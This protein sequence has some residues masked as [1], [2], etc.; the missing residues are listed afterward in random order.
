MTLVKA[1]EHHISTIKPLSG[2]EFAETTIDKYGYAL[3]S[4]KKFLKV[5]IINKISGYAS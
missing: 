3:S 5:S 2:I 1:Y 4:I